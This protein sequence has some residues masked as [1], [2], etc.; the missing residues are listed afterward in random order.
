M[1]DD[2]ERKLRNMQDRMFEQNLDLVYFSKVETRFDENYLQNLLKIE[3]LIQRSVANFY[4]ETK[5]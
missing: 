4:M 2:Y 3:A 5:N 1:L